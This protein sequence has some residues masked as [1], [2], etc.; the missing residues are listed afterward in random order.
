MV[1]F[2]I[3]SWVKRIGGRIYSGTSTTSVCSTFILTPSGRFLC[4]YSRKTSAVS[5]VSLFSCK[6]DRSLNEQLE[7]WILA[8]AMFKLRSNDPTSHLTSSR[9]LKCWII[10]PICWVIQRRHFWCWVKFYRDNNCWVRTPNHSFVLR[11]WVNCWI[12][13]P[14][15]LGRLTMLGGM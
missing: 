6:K 8:S 15:L 9:W 11:C 7:D 14:R 13:W 1:F 2:A 4:M 3:V 10:W 5:P 12:V